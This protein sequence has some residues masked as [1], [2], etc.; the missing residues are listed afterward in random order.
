MKLHGLA[1][2]SGVERTEIARPGSYDRFRSM[3]VSLFT[4]INPG[5]HHA[6][7]VAVVTTGLPTHRATATR[8]VQHLT[9]LPTNQ[10][11]KVAPVRRTDAATL[12]LAEREHL[13]NTPE[14]DSLLSELSSTGALLGGSAVSLPLQKKSG[15]LLA[16]EGHEPAVQQVK[17]NV[18]ANMPLPPAKLPPSFR[19]MN[20]DKPDGDE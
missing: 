10:A 5:E 7:D 18:P 20:E 11:A 9:A 15:A 12:R 3:F 14:A 17:L 13:P 2:T 19:A 6:E 8:T 4:F 16:G 1:R